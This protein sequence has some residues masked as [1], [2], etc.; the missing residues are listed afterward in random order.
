M[1]K[2]EK[3]NRNVENQ[4]TVLKSKYVYSKHTVYL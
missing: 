4:K 2:K 3:K 1:P